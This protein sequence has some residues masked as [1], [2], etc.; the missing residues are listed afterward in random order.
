MVT[1]G[2][3]PVFRNL[4][5]RIARLERFALLVS[6]DSLGALLPNGKRPTGA[7]LP[8]L[9]PSMFHIS[10]PLVRCPGQDA[11]KIRTTVKVILSF[12]VVCTGLEPVTPSMWTM[13]STNWANRPYISTDFW[14]LRSVSHPRTPNASEKRSNRERKAL[15]HDVR[16]R[17]RGII[18]SIHLKQTY[19]RIYFYWSNRSIFP[20]W[21]VDWTSQG[22]K[23]G[24]FYRK[25]N[26][27]RILPRRSH[28]FKLQKR[29][30]GSEFWRIVS[31]S[32]M[33]GKKW[34][35]F[36]PSR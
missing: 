30:T 11:I 27:I 24:A 21:K 22:E 8:L 29:K 15:Y 20:E 5:R 2:L 3:E 34:G 9:P 10:D 28:M 17:S 33:F 4:N 7:P 36:T 32:P 18:Y 13:C 26:E 25:I 12:Y 19:N 1:V 6:V 31:I 35:L 14:A 23:Q 16:I